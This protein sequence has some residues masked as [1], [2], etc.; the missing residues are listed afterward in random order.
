MQTKD[1]LVEALVIGCAVGLA[2]LIGLLA[3]AI[4]V[5]VSVVTAPAMAWRAWKQMADRPK[6]W[7]P[8]PVCGYLHSSEAIDCPV[9]TRRI[10][11]L[12]Q[13]R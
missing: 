5:L 10:D 9:C 11:A 4:F 7:K 3:L 12:V 2:I 8:C 1:P 6:R 13:K